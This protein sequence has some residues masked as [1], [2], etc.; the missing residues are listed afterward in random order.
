MT[1]ISA[2]RRPAGH[3]FTIAEGLPMA[4]E[5][6][7]RKLMWTL[8]GLLLAFSAAASDQCQIQAGVPFA[9]EFD[10]PPEFYN[11]ASERL[12]TAGELA[13]EDIAELYPMGFDVVV[14]VRPADP[15]VVAEERA[16]VE[17]EGLV[18]HHLPYRDDGVAEA[19][20]AAFR[21]LLADPKDYRILVHCKRGSRAGGF[22]A[23]FYVAEGAA[24]E[25]ALV[26]ARA[27]GLN[28]AM[29]EALIARLELPTS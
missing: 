29:E 4:V 18:Y 23:S 7:M 9:H 25:Q 21:A 26:A 20:L 17:A 22:L 14:D 15:E 8:T 24:P 13:P 5:R 28:K 27:S 11:R 16:L 2:I 19:D 6:T 1:W 12:A 10:R 3:N